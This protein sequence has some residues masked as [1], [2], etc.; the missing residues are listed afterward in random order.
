MSDAT[1]ARMEHGKYVGVRGEPRRDGVSM[2][3]DKKT[4]PLLKLRF[5]FRRPTGPGLLTYL[6][7]PKV[8]KTR[9]LLSYLA[10]VAS[11][12]LCSLVQVVARWG[13]CVPCAYAL[14]GQDCHSAPTHAQNE[15][16]TLLRSL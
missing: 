14:R 15:K 13:A 7:V 11:A 1:L 9:N 4:D 6:F 12:R 2:C 8:P 16:L 5:T 10:H 3:Y